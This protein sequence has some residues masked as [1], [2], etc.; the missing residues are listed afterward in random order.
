MDNINNLGTTLYFEP[1]TKDIII[2]EIPKYY[3]FL[4]NKTEIPI[5]E[6]LNLF[7]ICQ[8]PE[9]NAY[10]KEVLY[11]GRALINEKFDLE[12]KVEDLKC[13][14]CSKIFSFKTCGFW[15]CE[16]QFEGHKIKEGEIKYV[17][18]VP[19]ETKD[20]DFEYYNPSENITYWKNLIIYILSKKD[21][22]FK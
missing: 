14:F 11:K 17:I 10:K 5:K 22:K 16:Y 4:K 8:N 12:K 1:E 7:G 15:K 6:G 19:K 18:T 3:N 13:P 21:I 9:C 20:N 2:W